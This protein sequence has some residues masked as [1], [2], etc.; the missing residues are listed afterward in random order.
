MYVYDG[1]LK[2]IIS[3]FENEALFAGKS[4]DFFFYISKSGELKIAREN[5]EFLTDAEF[6][7]P[8][9]AASDSAQTEGN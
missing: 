4:K 2:T 9:P 8:E 6:N 7:P 5:G 1:E 3:D